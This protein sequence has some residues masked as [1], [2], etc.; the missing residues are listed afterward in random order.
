MTTSSTTE[1]QIHYRVCNY[2]E[3][4]CGVT[5][6]Y[7][8]LADNDARKIKVTPDKDDPFSRGGMC[9]K[10]AAFGALHYDPSR[11]K[12]PVKKVGDDWQEISWE[13]AYDTI[14]TKIKGIRSQYG[15][16]TV[17][18]YLGNPIVHNLGM[19]LFISMLLKA[20]GSKN[21]YSATSMDQL[22]HHFAAH[23]MFGHTMRIPLPDI[24]RTDYMILMGS[25]PLVSNGSIMTAAGVDKRLRDIQQR[26]G[27]FIVIDPRKTETANIASEH[28]FIRPGSDVYFLLALLHIIF[29]DQKVNLGRLT[30]HVEGFDA[31]PPLVEEYSPA[32]VA[33]LIGIDQAAI[34]QMAAE[35]CSHEKAVIHGRM[36]L[37]T[38]AHGGLCQWLINTINIV[39][40]HF[41]TPGG[42]MF[43]S[44][45]IEAVRGD[46]QRKAFG[47]WKSRVHALK[48]FA[49]ELPVSTMADEFKTDG[50][51]Q[52][53]AFMTVCGNPVLT[54]PNGKRLDEVLPNVEF[55]FSIDNFINETTRHADLILPTPMGLEIDHYDLVFNVLAVSNNARFS[56]ALFP[57]E[58]DRPYDWQVLKE[59]A[60]RLSRKGLSFRDRMS[61]PRGIINMGL[62]L[63]PYGKLSSPRRWF[64][65]LSLKKLIKSKHGIHLGP[66]KPRIPECLITPDKKI[67]LA[68]DVFLQRLTEVTKDELPAL[69]SEIQQQANK[70]ELLLVGRRNV[71]TNNSWMHQV[72]KLSISKMTR[73]TVMIHSDDAERLRIGDGEDVKVSSRVGAIVLP[74]EISNAMMPG[75]VSIPHGFGHNR[76]GTRV[77][78]ADIKPGVSVNDIT[79]HRRID[80]LTGNAAFSGQVVKIEPIISTN[81]C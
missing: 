73:C 32:R 4:M 56:S 55:M 20:I 35:Y 68:A 75:V 17:A 66:L 18:S 53:K 61:T 5:V 16:D 34:E 26:N 28:Y 58:K 63:G 72:R 50:K 45:A 31:L 15:V 64:T 24:D 27:K 23:F 77:P 9:P 67:Q 47:R 80:K 38:Q 39:T 46:K 71:S 60:G 6:R 7:D 1:P 69:A 14:E 57:P 74:A 3:A 40:G 49:G 22:P 11:L 19:M 70:Q 41:D 37:S 48:E 12:K 81:S 78:I 33:P 25:N 62:M 36:G 59:L 54:S 44:P 10:A 13:E 21:V 29:R 43:T 65:G 79:D 30:D 76:A 2:C 51:G 52:I 8:A 42:M